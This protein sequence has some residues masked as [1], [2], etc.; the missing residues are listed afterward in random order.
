MDQ[1]S[2]SVAERLLARRDASRLWRLIAR[3]VWPVFGVVATFLVFVLPMRANPRPPNLATMA[4]GVGTI[5]LVGLYMRARTLAGHVAGEPVRHDAWP[6]AIAFSAAARALGSAVLVMVGTALLPVRPFDGGYI[7]SRLI[8]L[9][10]SAVLLG[11]SALLLLG[12]V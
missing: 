8:N 9:A 6:P 4:V 11:V 3:P 12:W 2:G 1:G 5:A 7:R 10:V